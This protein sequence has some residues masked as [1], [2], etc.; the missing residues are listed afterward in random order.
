M[1]KYWHLKLSRFAI[2]A[3]GLL[4]SGAANA[5]TE[6]VLHSFNCSDGRLPLAGLVS[7]KGAL[8]GT[9]QYGGTCG[10]QLPHGAVFSITPGGTEKVLYSFTSNPDGAM[11]QSEL[12]HV[13]GVLYGT[14]RMGGFYGLGSV[15]AMTPNGRETVLHSFGGGSDG[16]TPTSGLIDVDGTLYGTTV[17]GGAHDQG[18]VFAITPAGTMTV[19][20]TFTGGSDGAH[21]LGKLRNVKGVLYGT[22][23]AGGAYGSGTV[24]SLTPGGTQKTI[25]SFKGGSDGTAPSAGLTNIKDTLYGTTTY[26][27]DSN[28]GTV[29]SIAPDGTKTTLHSFG[30]DQDDGTYPYAALTHSNGTLYGTTSGGGAYDCGSYGCGTV[31]SITPDGTYT[32]LHSFSGGNDGANPYA[33]LKAVDG[34]FYGTTEAGGTY[35][36]GTVYSIAP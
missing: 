2:A 6:T 32:V 30:G 29:F 11:P 14:T 24:F 13:Q 15:F 10:S 31:F 3:I 5:A 23:V 8:I 1:R 27:G 36:G 4:A 18:V 20:Y 28:F 19:L 22:A 34:T 7:F 25:Y 33:P 17:V 21:P 12:K 9:T 35:D 16:S 26:G